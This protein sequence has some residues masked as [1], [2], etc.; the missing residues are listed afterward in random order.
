MKQDSAVCWLCGGIIFSSLLACAGPNIPGVN[1]LRTTA[2]IVTPEARDAVVQSLEKCGFSITSSSDRYVTG[3]IFYVSAKMNINNNDWLSF[4]L[5]NYAK[6]DAIEIG[7]SQSSR[8]QSEGFTPE[9]SEHFSCV[10]G[11]IKLL[12]PGF[13]RAPAGE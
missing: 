13:I 10:E 7:E 11:N 5:Y 1:V 2:K 9:A 12:L 3:H 8:Y 4:G 6:S